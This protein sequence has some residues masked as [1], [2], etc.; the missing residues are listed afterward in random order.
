[1]I[2]HSYVASGVAPTNT[3]KSLPACACQLHERFQRNDRVDVVLTSP[4]A[5]IGQFDIISQSLPHL[6]ESVAGAWRI[7]RVLGPSPTVEDGVRSNGDNVILKQKSSPKVK[8]VLQPQE[9]HFWEAK[10]ANT[11]HPKT[12]TT[13]SSLFRQEIP[14]KGHIEAWKWAETS[15]VAFL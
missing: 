14:R 12:I 8:N 2:F 4:M 1:M 3:S 11:S 9:N 5:V 10:E 13:S 15:V 6:I 7:N